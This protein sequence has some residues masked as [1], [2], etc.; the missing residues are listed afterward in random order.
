MGRPLLSIVTPCLNSGATVLQALESVRAQG[1]GEEV[2]H[3]VVDGGSTDGTLDVLATAPGVIWSSEPDRGLSDAMNKGVARARGE[4]VGWLNADD[5]YLPGALRR[6]RDA[7]EERHDARWLTGPCLIVDAEGR[8]IRRAVTRYKRFFLRH[9]SLASLLVQNYVAAPATFVR[10]DAIV[11][12]GGFDERFRYSMDY[13][14]WLKLARRAAPVVVDEPLAAFRMAGESLSMTGFE[15]QFSEHA[16][17][18]REHGEGHRLS[19][20]ANVVASRLIVWIYRRL[21]ARD[22]GA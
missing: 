22:D 20:A 17:N 12:A 9:H 10:R 16:R 13:D 7:L 18:A 1:L 19:V 2:E 8:E 5:Y 4:F 15:R 3:V 14:L 11:E 6:V 21:R